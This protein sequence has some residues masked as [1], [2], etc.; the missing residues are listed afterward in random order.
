MSK[1]DFILLIV[2]ISFLLVKTSSK[3]NYQD[4]NI[5]ITT[6]MQSV[7]I[8]S[9]YNIYLFNA[10]FDPSS[11]KFI[12]LSLSPNDYEKDYNHIFVSIPGEEGKVPSY[13]DSDYKTVDKNTSLV[14]NIP[15]DASS[16]KIGIE[17]KNVCNFILKYQ[18]V[19]KIPVL[20]DRSF[21][22][23]LKSD[24]EIELFY[25][26]IILDD[27]SNK[28][29][30]FSNAPPEF[31]LTIVNENNENNETISPLTEFYNGYGL[32]VGNKKYPEGNFTFKLN[33]D[34]K[35]EELIH[36]SNRLLTTEPRKLSV[37]DFHNSII[38]IEDLG[39]ECFILPEEEND[40]NYNLNFLSYTKNI[41]VTFDGIDTFTINSE[42]D[43]IQIDAKKY[44]QMCLSS[45]NGNIATTTFQ[46]LDG[47]EQTEN[48]DAQMPL[49]R[50]L[51]KK[52]KLLKDQIAYYKL[53]Y[54]PTDSE[55]LLMNLKSIEGKAKLYY[56]ICTNY[57][58]CN[59]Q[60]EDL[61]ELETEKDIN[62][63][64]FI[65]KLIEKDMKK[66]Y[67][68]PKFQVAVVYCDNNEEEKDCDYY[69]TISNDKDV[70]NIIENQ[71]YYS[72]VNFNKSDEYQLNIF[73]S[74]TE[75]EYLF[76]NLYSYTGQGQISI[77]YDKEMTKEIDTAKITA[78][79]NVQTALITASDLQNKTL[80]GNYYIKVE[81]LSNTIYSIY[82]YTATKDVDLNT[83]YISSNEVN[84]QA[85]KIDGQENSFLV[86]N[87][88]IY[89]KVPF[90][91]EY[92]S[93]NCDLEVSLTG[94]TEVIDDRNHQFIIDTTKPYYDSDYYEMKIKVK[95]A[96][97]E[98]PSPDML[99]LVALM[100][101]E[102]DDNRENV[103]SDG[104]VQKGKLTKNVD[105][106]NYL[107]S[108][109]VDSLDD[110]LTLSFQKDSNYITEVNYAFENSDLFTYNVVN[111][112][113]KFVFK[114]EDFYNYC[115]HYN[116]S[117]TLKIQIK[118]NDE[119][120]EKLNNDSYI[121]FMLSINNKKTYPSYLPKDTLIKN[122]LQT[123]QYQYYY[124]DIGKDE[125]CDI[126]LDFNEGFGQA[127]AKIVKMDDVEENPN[128]NRRVV[129]PLPG[130][131]ENYI[132]DQYTKELKV[133]KNMTSKCDGGCEIY[134]A[135]FHI[136]QNYTDLISTFSIFYR[137]NNNIVYLSEN[138][139]GHGNLETLEDIHIFRTKINKDTDAVIFNIIGDH[140]I[141]YINKGEE[142]PSPD[143][144]DY[145]IDSDIQ[146]QLIIDDEE[147]FV[148]QLFTY[149]V[150][151]TKLDLNN[152]RN[153]DI[154]L[155][156]PDSKSVNIELIDF[157][158]NN[159]CYF[160]EDNKKC[161]YMLPVE[162][163]NLEQSL[164][165]FTADNQNTYVYANYI[166]MVEFDSLTPEEKSEK[167]PKRT[168]ESKSYLIL[169]IT[170]RESEVYVL[171]TVETSLETIENNSTA[172]FVVGGFLH[173]NISFLRPNSYSFYSIKYTDTIDNIY[174][175][176]ESEYMCNLRFIFISGRG[177][178]TQIDLEKVVHFGELDQTN[179]FTFSFEPQLKE[180]KLFEV[181]I[182]D[183]DE[184]ED[185]YF[186]TY[187]ESISNK[188]NIIEMKYSDVYEQKYEL[189]MS[190][191]ITNFLPLSFY[192]LL[193]NNI[194]KDIQYIVQISDR[195]PY[196]REF[197]RK[198]F[199][200]K[201][202]ILNKTTIE[203]IILNIDLIEKEKDLLNGVYYNKLFTSDI[204]LTK[205]IIDKYAIYKENYFFIFISNTVS[206]EIKFNYTE[207]DILK[208]SFYFS[209]INSYFNNTVKDTENKNLLLVPQLGTYQ[210][211]LE[212]FVDGKS[213]LNDY[214]ITVNQYIDDNCNYTTNLTS[215]ID[216]QYRENEKQYF[217]I[218]INPSIHY[219][220]ANVIKKN[221]NN[222]NTIYFLKYRIDTD[223]PP[224]Y[225]IGD[226][227]VSYTL[228][229]AYLKMNFAPVKECGDSDSDCTPHDDFTVKYV[230][231][232][233]DK[234]KFEGIIIR[235]I[236]VD[237]EPIMEK[238]LIRKYDKKEDK[239]EWSIKVTDDEP[240]Y[241]IQIVAY[242]SYDENEEILV[243]KSFVIDRTHTGEDRTFEFWI[244]LFSFIGI[245]IITFGAMYVYIY[246][247]IEIS[248][249]TLMLN[250]STKVSLV[251]KSENSNESNP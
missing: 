226:R 153:Y 155:S 77:Y 26:P 247:K 206:E 224:F 72:S 132:F 174:L 214:D 111:T 230:A 46:I 140:T 64:I 160:S 216:F 48:Q 52:S 240:D 71:K 172:N 189:L 106:V 225:S 215:I 86:K 73:D 227:S 67:L 249:R 128:Y 81:G 27:F 209:N 115:I 194:T 234:K 92:N 195:I 159:P 124:L 102:V 192:E 232:F 129:L 203:D 75:L 6:N 25:T 20:N 53:H 113:K 127:I 188:T 66:P 16:G 121:D 178:I 152:I 117:C 56:G 17:C 243:Y 38:D 11:G 84:I 43:Y 242:A 119:E 95:N 61:E 60:K 176:I 9:E 10:D 3:L 24:E 197:D 85:I 101:G 144:K 169:N 221:N 196:V 142:V 104:V 130:M 198:I 222:N 18:I 139:F 162:T 116:E 204:I 91:Y 241:F 37:G 170:E 80:N 87:K 133:T 112:E 180:Q 156:T 42:S 98:E 219:I 89:K 181:I 199:Y 165:L 44:E 51:P 157:L 235:N 183:K 211:A 22:L 100:G 23:I 191:Q 107:Y 88:G 158:H 201:G 63:N 145:T 35:Q 12:Y 33:L 141:V 1:R 109:I 175:G 57:S 185:V 236:I 49:Y 78:Y 182:S 59:F 223:Y 213:D 41:L 4:S 146:N 94:E 171:V 164:Y 93:L 74:E 190:D 248:R 131:E 151:T 36:V 19:T 246:A 138:T 122:V 200:V 105:Y 187:L 28:F 150:I 251:R 21:D 29:T 166:S 83:Y 31:T 39:Q 135:T 250:N 184:D 47:T 136:D 126:I 45:S 218:N 123:N 147:S 245:T 186:F 163:Y 149:I 68:D 168:P 143:N 62:N 120:K 202:Y 32:L 207:I 8:T 239:I 14:I 228:K 193:P 90:L 76:I 217:G 58:N 134:I 114:K 2:T 13:D 179:Y 103:L 110:D 205:D 229:N 96:D 238:E 161:N 108:F 212:V 210:M 237:E 148:D 244:I 208:S 40:K 69:I 15:S 30:F 220:V 50:G 55:Y 167:L 99:C 231:S 177:N 34:G 125:E 137:K 233:Y 65:K 154:K 5:T 118:I 70:I 97:I 54:Y 79:Q 7:E 82:Y 173:P